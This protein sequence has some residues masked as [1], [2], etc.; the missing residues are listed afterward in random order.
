LPLGLGRGLCFANCDAR[1]SEELTLQH[2]AP[3]L[4]RRNAMN[5]KFA[6]KKDATIRGIRDV[7]APD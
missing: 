2:P 6:P 7:A 4:I 5:D 3:R 1:V